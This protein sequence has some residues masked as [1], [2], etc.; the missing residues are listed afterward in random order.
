MKSLSF[1]AAV[2][3]ALSLALGLLATNARAG[4]AFNI[5]RTVCPAGAFQ[6][7]QNF[8][9][10][11]SYYQP[12]TNGG[13]GLTVSGLGAGL[14]AYGTLSVPFESTAEQSPVSPVWTVA[15][16]GSSRANGEQICAQQV[17]WDQSGNATGTGS[18]DPCTSGS[19]SAQTLTSSGSSVPI[20]GAML[21]SIAAENGATLDNAR[22]TF[23]A[24]GT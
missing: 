7:N 2:V 9:N 23:T 17:A 10:H 13:C 3:G 20:S 4:Y 6:P 15:V 18:S 21:C 5:T 8:E 24:G 12:V 11:G 22:V 19:F 14:F 1:S 16:H